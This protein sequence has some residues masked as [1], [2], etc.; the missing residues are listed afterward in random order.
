MR[1]TV[2]LLATAALATLLVGGAAWATTVAFAPAKNRPAGD[3]PQAVSAG[4]LDGDGDTDLVTANR[5]ADTVSVLIRR[6]DGT[7]R[8][9]RAYPAGSRPTDVIAREDLDGDGDRDLAAANFGSGDVSVRM[10]RGDGTFSA[11]R[12]YAAGPG[13]PVAVEAGD[14]DGDGDEDLVAANRGGGFVDG[15]PDY[16][17]PGTVSV[18]LNAGDGSFAPS[19]EFLAGEAFEPRDLDRSDLDGDGDE[20][21]VVALASTR[22]GDGGL[23][24]LLNGGGGA[25]GAPQRYGHLGSA[26]GVVADDLDGDGDNDLA[27]ADSIFNEVVVYENDGGGAFGHKGGYSIDPDP[28]EG[29]QARNPYALTEAD[30]DRDGD[31]DIATSNPGA[32]NGRPDNVSVLENA[33]DGTLGNPV[34][35]DAGVG[36]IGITRARM[37]A[38]RMPDL[39][40]ANAG[41]DDVSVLVNTTRP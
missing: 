10:G 11:Q 31:V 4:D 32:I 24:V 29:A 37:N 14:L 2:L 12:R 40:V 27:A 6:R 3:G 23:A 20:D 34:L 19:R 17:I 5:D 30:F 36:P 35:L 1:R 18:F 28:P 8:A 41:S 9:P 16:S 15:R 39:V 38:D 7:F 21:L 25:F 13:G 33:G 26:E 22:A